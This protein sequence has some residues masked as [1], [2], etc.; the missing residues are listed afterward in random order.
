VN[1]LTR[2]INPNE[3]GKEVIPMAYTPE[4]SYRGSATLR[5]LAWFRRKPMT[6]T[7]EALLEATARTMAEIRPGEVCAKCK[8]DSICEECPFQPSAKN[9]PTSSLAK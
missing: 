8:D 2:R 7:I 9:E 1:L 5:R 3:N 6:E 4:L